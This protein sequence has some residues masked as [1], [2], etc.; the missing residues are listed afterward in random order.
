MDVKEIVKAFGAYYQNSGQNTKRILLALL[1]GAETPKYMT[2]IK[3]DDTIFRLAQGHM[4]KLVQPFRK[5]WHPS[6][7]ASF[8]PNE[9][10]LYKMK[11]DEDITPDEIEATWLGF[12]A[13]ANLNR[14]DWPLIKYLIEKMYIPQIHQDMELDAYFWGV[15]KEPQG[16]EA[17]K[18]SDC[19]DGLHIQLQRGVDAGTINLVESIGELNPA[20]I[21]DQVEAFDDGIKGVYRNVPMN[22]FMSPENRIAYLRDKRAQGF[23]D[24][25]SDAEVNSGVDFTPRRVVGLPSMTGYKYM[26]ATPQDN[27]LHLTKREANKTSIKIEESKREVALMCD[28]WEGVGIGMNGIVWTTQPKTLTSDPSGEAA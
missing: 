8:T 1:Q 3:T 16:D 13:A 7:A 18:P 5:G 24:M 12:L 10:K 14:K 26:F 9:L 22:I 23:Y 2:R 11:V 15:R 6:N 25:K 27:L 20:Q 28:W 21:F 19:M 17:V 4:K